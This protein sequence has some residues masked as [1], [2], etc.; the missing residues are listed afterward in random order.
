MIQLAQTTSRLRLRALAARDLALFRTLYT[1]AGTMRFIGRPLSPDTVEPSLHATLDAARK[2]RGPR[3]FVIVE[4]RRR[5]AIGLCSIRRVSTRERS[6]EAGIMLVPQACGLGHGR[7]AFGALIDAAFRTLPIDTVWVQY[8][9]ANAAMAR[10]CGSLGFSATDGCRRPRGAR[11]GQCVSLLQRPG[12]CK[13][14]HQPP[15]G[16]AMSNIIGFLENAGRDAAM[17]H[18]SREQLLRMMQS[19]QIEPA[20][21]AALLQPERMAIDGLLGVRDT[22]YCQNTSIKPPKKAPPPKKTPVKAPPKKTPAKAPPKKAPAKKPA[23]KTPG[24][25]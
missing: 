18:A 2:P 19:E 15:R 11:P 21:S 5:R 13:K 10:L 8:R 24:K 7:D 4:R 9:P 16:V 25:R 14:S 20:L 22:M 17:R 23:K 12:G 3:F 6:A 1:D